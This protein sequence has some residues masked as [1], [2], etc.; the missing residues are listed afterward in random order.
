MSRARVIPKLILATFAA[1]MLLAG[2]VFS[3]KET[4][5]TPPPPP[6][7]VDSPEAL[8]AALSNASQ[9]R[10]Y[11]YIEPLFHSDYLFI[12][13]PDPLNPTQPVD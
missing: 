12:L 7:A 4:P 5:P 6:P 2:C 13:K 11:D 1:S 9:T 8:I 10:R 3:P